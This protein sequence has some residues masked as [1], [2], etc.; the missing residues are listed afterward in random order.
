MLLLP[1]F[2]GFLGGT[3]A[4]FYRVDC[5]LMMSGGLSFAR[6]GKKTK[7]KKS[8]YGF[9]ILHVICFLKMVIRLF[10]LPLQFHR[11]ERQ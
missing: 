7:N 11:A 2:N 8:Q 4:L 1:L 5:D 10:A 3:E 9:E 6:C